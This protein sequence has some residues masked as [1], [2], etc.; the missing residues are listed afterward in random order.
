M[1]LYVTIPCDRQRCGHRKQVVGVSSCSVHLSR[2]ANSNQAFELR[3]S[4]WAL[5]RFEMSQLDSEDSHSVSLIYSSFRATITGYMSHRLMSPR[6]RSSAVSFV[7]GDSISP[8][9]LAQTMLD[10]W[11]SALPVK[12]LPRIR[13][14]G[15]RQLA[16]TLSHNSPDQSSRFSD[17]LRR[18]EHAHDTL[19]SYHLARRNPRNNSDLWSF[20]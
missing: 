6:C 8:L 11:S 2:S 18:T 15:G 16:D 1:V 17:I 14:L 9:G 3:G 12:I 13:K 7:S 20:S 19:Y 5:D 4:S 10:P